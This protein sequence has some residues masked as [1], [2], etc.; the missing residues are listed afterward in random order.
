MAIGSSL[1]ETIRMK[2]PTMQVTE[3]I[4]GIPVQATCSSCHNTTFHAGSK[5]GGTAEE[6]ERTLKALFDHH[7]ETIHLKEDASQAAAR[8]V[9]EATEN[10]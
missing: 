7:F 8:V 5:I 6:N 3:R 9:R 2:K 4:N 1:W 10:H